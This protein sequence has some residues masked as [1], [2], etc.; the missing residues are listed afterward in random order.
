MTTTS[1]PQDRFLRKTTGEVAQCGTCVT[2]LATHIRRTRRFDI[3][4]CDACVE[5]YEIALRKQFRLQQDE[6]AGY[7]EYVEWDDRSDA[8]R[9]N[10]SL[11]A[12]CPL[13]VM[14]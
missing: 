11:L 12:S 4:L 10:D 14:E 9:E 7:R 6:D 1:I 13:E 3:Y 2:R 8:V 5:Q